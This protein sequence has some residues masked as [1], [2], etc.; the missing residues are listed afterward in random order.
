MSVRLRD[1]LMRGRVCFFNE[2]V[3]I[4]VDGTALERPQTPRSRR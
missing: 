3:G 2:F 4:V 1:A